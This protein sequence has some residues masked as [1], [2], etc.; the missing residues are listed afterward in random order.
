MPATKSRRAPSR[1]SLVAMTLLVAGCGGSVN[2]W[3]FG[4]SKT[5]E[6]NRSPEN[7]TEYRCADGRSFHVRTLEGGAAVWLILPD[8]QVRLERSAAGYSNGI[9]TFRADGGAAAL[10]DGGTAWNG[11]KVPGAEKP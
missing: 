2:L 7:A 9:T 3:P 10:T 5:P 8:R 4:D 11:C 1:W 6:R